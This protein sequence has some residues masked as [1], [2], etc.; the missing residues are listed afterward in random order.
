MPRRPREIEHLLQ[1]KFGFSPAREHSSDHR[2]YELRLP[3]LPPILTK[4]SHTKEEVGRKLES[5]IARQLRVRRPYFVGMMD[6]TYNRE[7]Y[8]RQL[9]ENPF[10]PFDYR[11]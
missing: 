1:T 3:G 8:Y 9:R 7:D 10:P 11:F 5:M 6:C 2:W 4:V